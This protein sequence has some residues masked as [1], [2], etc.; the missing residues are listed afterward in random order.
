VC[1]PLTSLTT[2]RHGLAFGERESPL[3]PWIPGRFV[4]SG[5]DHWKVSSHR[6]VARNGYAIFNCRVVNELAKSVNSIP[7]PSGRASR[8]PLERARERRFR[9]G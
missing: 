7:V 6:A 9:G 2:R 3:V 5:A 1:H 8:L 4:V